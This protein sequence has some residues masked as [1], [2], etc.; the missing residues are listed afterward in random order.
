MPLALALLAPRSRP[1]GADADGHLCGSITGIAVGGPV[2]GGA[3]AQ[4]IDWRFIF[5]LNV[6]IGLV[7][8]PLVLRRTPESFGPRLG[9]DVLRRLL[10]ASASLGVVC[11]TRKRATDARDGRS[12]SLTRF[13]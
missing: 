11:T 4:G 6:P 7:V 2:D 5:W 9:L 10:V 3:I 12:C 8:M 1:S 13:V